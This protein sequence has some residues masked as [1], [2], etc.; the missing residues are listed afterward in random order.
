M[1]FTALVGGL[2]LLSVA[3][4]LGGVYVYYRSTVEDRTEEVAQRFAEALREAEEALLFRTR[5]LAEMARIEAL[6]LDARLVREIQVYTLRWLKRDGLQVLGM[7]PASYW[8]ERGLGPEVLRRAFAGVPSIQLYAP[9]DGPPMLLAATPRENQAG[10][11]EVIVASLPLGPAPLARL[12]KRSGGELALFDGEGRLLSTS[13]TQPAALDGAEL[14]RAPPG[15]VVTST[16]GEAPY[17]CRTYPFEVGQQAYGSYAVL[18]PLTELRQLTIRLMAWQL[19][20]AGLFLGLF[21]VLYRLII[22]RTASDL[23]ALTAWARAFS[24]EQPAAPPNLGRI[25]E[26][27]LLARTFLALA[28]D[29][30]SALREVG[31]KNRELGAVN[32]GLEHVV[33]E[34]TREA[35]EQRVLLDSV[36]AGM[37]QAVLLVEASG[38]VGYANKAARER[39][40]E[41]EEQ[42]LA[43]LLGPAVAAPGP[44]TAEAEVVRDD[45]RYLINTAP[46]GGGRW[47]LVAQDV[48]ERRALEHRVLQSQKL[49]SVGRLAGGVAH[50]FNNV[51]GSIVPCVDILRR[52]LS[53]P[54]LLTYLDTIDTAAARAAEVVRQ[55]LTFS[56]ADEFRPIPTD[57]NAA[58]EGA[59][60]LLRTGLKGVELRWHPGEGL[61]WIRGDETQIQQVVLNL[62]LNA[63]DAMAG[64]G[65]LTV[66]TR[67]GSHGSVLLSVEDTGPGIPPHLADR[68]FDPFFT[69]KA[70]GKG[71]GL[72]LSIVYGVVE[73]HQGRLRLESPPGRGARFE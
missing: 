54:K 42:S 56:R 10:V 7:G 22:V 24:P 1:S 25:D 72:G 40:G 63:V 29:L 11:A 5:I 21:Y 49:E 23:E 17:A 61:P 32:V 4:A 62:A 58:V 8:A 48:T 73:R 26:V 28:T 38:R 37:P 57:L 36:L 44:E 14:G 55:L 39:F 13:L 59:L 12:S 18:W 30:Q 34:K 46:L 71:T 35:E 47:V 53:D 33:A 67:A 3:V 27:G 6:G 51:L 15:A 31:V 2:A 16:V 70:P 20:G 66:E 41:A 52:R 45:A 19:G 60:T 43:E 9:D 64:Q 69:T 65:T 68:I 50:D